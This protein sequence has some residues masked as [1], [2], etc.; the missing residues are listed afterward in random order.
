MDNIEIEKRKKEALNRIIAGMK[1]YFQQRQ[2]RKVKVTTIVKIGY[3]HHSKYEPS[4]ICIWK[5]LREH[6]KAIRKQGFS[7]RLKNLY[8]IHTETKYA[9]LPG[10]PFYM[11][12][13]KSHRKGFW[14]R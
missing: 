10:Y 7:G 5:R 1:S 12:M 4:D 9:N 8:K 6:R 13:E 3:K 14:K 11:R 2:N